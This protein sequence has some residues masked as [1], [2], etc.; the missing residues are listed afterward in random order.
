MAQSSRSDSDPASISLLI[1]FIN[2]LISLWRKLRRQQTPPPSLSLP[3][4]IL[5]HGTF[6]ATEELSSA[7]WWHSNGETA[8]ALKASLAG[9]GLAGA[10]VE[11]FQWS[12]KNEMPARRHGARMLARRLMDLER[13]GRSYHIVAHS[14]GGSVAWWALVR[15]WLGGFDAAALR[16]FVTVGTPFLHFQPVSLRMPMI[17]A[18]M[19]AAV[20]T[21]LIYR[22]QA[23]MAQAATLIGDALG[24]WRT[25]YSGMVIS[26]LGGVLAITLLM[27][28]AA[29]DDKSGNSDL[30]IWL[31]KGVKFL[32]MATGAALLV[33]VALGGYA[34]FNILRASYD[35][36][37]GH[38]LIA[39]GLAALPWF[40]GVTA[41][42][43]YVIWLTG[44]A[45]RHFVIFVGSRGE[46]LAWDALCPHH[47]AIRSVD[48]EAISGLSV[49]AAR[50]PRIA[51]RFGPRPIAL[52]YAWISDRLA[53]PAVD[54]FVWTRL[55]RKAL[56]LVDGN[57]TIV[58]VGAAPLPGNVEVLPLSA[59]VETEMVEL[60]NR[61][62]ARE[63]FNI[64]LN[65]RTLAERISAGIDLSDIPLMRIAEDGLVH[66]GY[67]SSAGVRAL[68]AGRI[69]L[70]QQGQFSAT[71]Y[72]RHAA[73]P[74]A[75]LPS[76][77][78]GGLIALTWTAVFA[79][80]GLAGDATLQ[81]YVAGKDDTAMLSDLVGSPTIVSAARSDSPDLPI[82]R[83]WLQGAV[84][85]G[86]DDDALDAARRLHDPDAR[87]LA[88]CYAAEAMLPWKGDK[89]TKA[90]DAVVAELPRIS[91]ER[92][93]FVEACAV[94]V[95]TQLRRTPIVN[96]VLKSAARDNAGT[97]TLMAAMAEGYAALQ[98]YDDVAMAYAAI[99]APRLR[100]DVISAVLE[101][102]LQP[103][104]LV[105]YR[106]WQ[107]GLEAALGMVELPGSQDI[108]DDALARLGTV[109]IDAAIAGNVDPTDAT[110]RALALLSRVNDPARSIALRV[111]SLARTEFLLPHNDLVSAVHAVNQNYDSLNRPADLEPVV[112]RVNA[113]LHEKEG[114]GKYVLDVDRM[115]PPAIET[116]L[117][118]DEATLHAVAG[119]G[120]AMIDSIVELQK[121]APNSWMERAARITR[122]L[123]RSATPNLVTDAE[124]APSP[125]VAAFLLGRLSDDCGM[126]GRRILREDAEAL[127]SQIDDDAVRSQVQTSIASRWAADGDVAKAR[128][129][130]GNCTSLQ[131]AHVEA[132]ALSHVAAAKTAQILGQPRRRYLNDYCMPYRG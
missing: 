132:T 78:L 52:F 2:G 88:Q 29:V 131:L 67:F 60:A 117:Y 72:V 25:G 46:A 1:L 63:M 35:A 96:T 100:V 44:R 5:V 13:E 56:G 8:D 30:Q 40:I 120:Q 33:E 102:R 129:A 93:P 127:V 55:Q 9:Q 74:P 10:E 79:L 71:H 68:I 81:R 15:L 124:N 51:P 90:I 37:T 11:S 94:R 103:R 97:E 27:V 118:D 108:H 125:A 28:A 17:A 65:L 84:L 83:G 111:E 121:H 48:D 114:I 62:A 76:P 45:I 38:E 14:H 128:S 75:P 6:A 58:G 7:C 123:P 110:D 47:V 99:R 113:L 95:L 43:S 105:M 112:G 126:P 119:N 115:E 22:R 31:G 32:L 59:D 39:F 116:A 4:I 50:P 66:C 122:D 80:A 98:S 23:D 36:E 3:V 130:C 86:R 19:A 107:R 87:A 85:A 57:R 91:T 12:G 104:L 26:A 89:A 73:T 54:E 109:L 69:A 24:V 18:T 42:L 77:R 106:D 21:M 53:A 101:A 92:K 41:A 70:A 61:A 82:V 20:T 16:S 49:M 64:R 34:F